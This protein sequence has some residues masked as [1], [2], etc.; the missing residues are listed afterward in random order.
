MGGG[1]IIKSAG[2][3]CERIGWEMAY[4]A[5]LLEAFSPRVEKR[6]CGFFRVEKLWCV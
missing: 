5:D 3:V 2:K 1:G 6:L 4:G